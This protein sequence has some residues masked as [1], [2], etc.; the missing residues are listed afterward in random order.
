[1]KLGE[2]AR[3]SGTSTAS[4]KYWIREGVLPPGELRNQTTAVY[5]RRHVE[6]IALITT[7]RAEYD[8]PMDRIRGLTR[9]IDDPQASLLDVMEA[10]QVL[11][12]GM[13]VAAQRDE[14]QAA[15]IGELHDR[16]GWLRFDSVAS[17]ALTRALADS[18]RVGYPYDLDDLLH[19][20]RA[21]EPIA[22][23]DIGSIQPEG[24]RDAVARNVLVA[25][26]AQHR[27]LVAMNQLA[28]TAAAVR[29][30]TQG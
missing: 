28:H 17:S 27:V 21:L 7:L 23:A 2:L 16:M 15:L 20:A 11:A 3:E 22:S 9:L 12:T 29:S 14:A 4:I 25:S 10:C 19:Y 13:A 26:A 6:R 30:A 18:A 24:T 1:M 8:A 5:D